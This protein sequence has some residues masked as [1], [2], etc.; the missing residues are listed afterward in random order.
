MLKKIFVLSL[1]L[2][3]FLA[4]LPAN[5]LA[6][7]Y[8]VSTS[9]SNSDGRSWSTAWNELSQ[10]NWSTVQPGDTI[11][12][13]G[14][15][16]ACARTTTVT[17]SSATPRSSSGG[18]CG[19]TY[20]TMLTPGKEGTTSNPITIKL[21][22]ES[23]RN[24]T[25]IFFGGRSTPVPYCGQSGYSYTAGLRQLIDFRGKKN[26]VIDGS[27]WGGI[28]VYGG[29][30]GV[31][32]S[33]T[34]ENLVLRH[35]EIFDNGNSGPDLPGIALSGTNVSLERSIVHDN[36]QDALQSGG[37]IRNFTM[38]QSWL[39]NARRHPTNTPQVFNY[40]THTDGIQVYSGG[41]QYGLTVEDS[42]I[43]PG[44]MQGFI[45]GDYTTSS[46]S[47]VNTGMMHDVTLKNLLVVNL[48]SLS[49]NA[50]LYTKYSS[51]ALYPNNPPTNYRLDRV[52]SYIGGSRNTWNMYILGSGHTVTNSIFVG[53]GSWGLTV[54]N[55]QSSNNISYNVSDNDNIAAD[56]NPNFV[57]PNFWDSA[58]N[59]ADFNF[60]SQSHPDKG[61]CV[62]S[63]TVLFSLKPGESCP[64][65]IEPTPSP[66]IAPSP[67]PAPTVSPT[68]TATSS[69]TPSPTTDL[70]WQAEEGS[71]NGFEVTADYI[72]QASEV[73]EPAAGGEARFSFNLLEPG[74]Y[75]IKAL[76]RASD[77]GSNSFFVNI[78]SQPS[79]PQ[80]IWDIEP[81]PNFQERIV[82]WR[83]SGLAES[84]YN[85]PQIFSLSAGNHT[86]IIRG[87]EANVQLDSLELIN[88]S[89][90]GDTNE[91]GRVDGVDYVIWLQYYN[92]NT[93]KGA[94]EGDFNGD[95]T[96]DGIDYVIWLQHYN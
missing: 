46:T 77:L 61:S 55:A 67:T 75:A 53:G 90:P 30:Y 62:V 50:N 23:G 41:D 95:G 34:S 45:L 91:D 25:A 96:V 1:F 83:G 8:Y 63:P 13:D 72:Y 85:R 36:G 20:R 93:S 56:A 88:F 79:S 19:I 42:I 38:R 59:F 51:S 66:T 18:S 32:L 2:L 44:F 78:D 15:S 60:S 54:R 71:L 47:W 86:I 26:L 92:Q 21:S 43:G 5:L 87:R 29:V 76:V 6:A 14:G 37:G 35:L 10:I 12:I 84:N 40:C 22:T 74:N 49:H 70:Y 28:K 65:S 68:A 16:T 52:T 7:N 94:A 11:Y 33:S 89:V 81:D 4:A 80:M 57:D 69:P 9:G 31:G 48:D 64:S 73:S 24:G 82:A 27:K 39:Y 17:G 3:L 58:T